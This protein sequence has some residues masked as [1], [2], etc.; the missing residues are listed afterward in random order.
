MTKAVITVPAYFNDAQRQ[1]TKDAGRIA[2]LEVL[3]IINEPTA[4][5]LAYGLDKEGD[6]TIL[7]YDLGGGTFDVSIL[8]LGD[9]IFEVKATAG[10]NRL[11]GDD[12]DQAIMDWLIEEFKAETGIDLRNDNMAMQRLKDAAE[13]AK[14]DLSSVLTTTISLPSSPPMPR[15]RSTLSA[16]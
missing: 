2:G 5:A 9:G 8:E 10:D 13:K 7:V 16:S 4:A 11:G 14:K 12:F 1:A 3:R 6:Q 15:G